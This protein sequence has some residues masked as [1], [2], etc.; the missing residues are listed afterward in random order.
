MLGV[1]RT[2][3]R[4]FAGAVPVF[5]ELLARYRQASAKSHPDTLALENNLAIT[6]LHAGQASEAESLERE[7][8]PSCARTTGS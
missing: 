2:S 6:L 1:I 8:R 5:R 7:V 4:D 3:R